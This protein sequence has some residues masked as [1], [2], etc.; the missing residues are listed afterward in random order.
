MAFDCHYIH[1]VHGK[2]YYILFLP[3]KI[4]IMLLKL[5]NYANYFFCA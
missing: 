4:Y 5:L 1:V 2:S 3:N